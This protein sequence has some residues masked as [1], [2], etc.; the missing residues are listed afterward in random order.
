MINANPN[1][2]SFTVVTPAATTWSMTN[3]SNLEYRLTNRQKPGN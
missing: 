1:D 2:Y 3:G